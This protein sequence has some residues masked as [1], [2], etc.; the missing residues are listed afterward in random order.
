MP[1][2]LLRL[3]STQDTSSQPTIND[4]R[5]Q[6]LKKTL[7]ILGKPALSVTELEKQLL[8]PS[9]SEASKHMVN[10]SSGNNST[11]ENLA[12]PVPISNKVRQQKIYIRVYDI[13]EIKIGT[14]RKLNRLMVIF[15]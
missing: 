5:E 12:K 4:E 11:I 3:F 6:E 7:G 15:I 10:N 9:S 1:A 13:S 14:I 8:Q 2:A